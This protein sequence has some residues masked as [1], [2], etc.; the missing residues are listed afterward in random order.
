MC[1]AGWRAA[2]MIH[3]TRC[4]R[5][6]DVFALGC[7][8]YY[9]LTGGRHPFGNRFERESNIVAGNFSLKDLA[10]IST[11]GA[12]AAAPARQFTA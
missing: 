7:V 4:G 12:H 8:I 3:G 1:V 9:V 11:V 2:E 6:V 5:S 10:H